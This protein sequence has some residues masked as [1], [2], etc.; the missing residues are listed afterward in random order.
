M[1]D[2]A[3]K[4]G[5]LLVTLQSIHAVVPNARTAVAAALIVLVA[6]L[7]AH[8]ALATDRPIA[9]TKLVLKRSASG[10]EK[11]IFLSK[12]PAFLFD[13]SVG[14]DDPAHAGATI[15]LF[16]DAEGVST[17]GVPAGSGV[18]GWV[19]KGASVPTFAYANKIAPAGPSLV[20]SLVLRHGKSMKLDARASGLALAAPEGAVGVRIT[21]GSFRNCVRFDGLT[22]HSDKPGSFVA[23]SVIATL[24]D[25]S[26]ASLSG[27][28]SGCS[29][30][31]MTCG[32]S[33][34]DGA[35]CATQDLSSCTC[36]SPAD[37][38][39][40]TY[41][42]CN[43]E[44]PAGEAC[45][46]TG[47]FPLSGCSCLPI[48]STPCSQFQCGGDCPAGEECNY[49]ERSYPGSSGCVCGPPG[50]CGSGGDDCPPGQHCA[51]GPPGTFCVP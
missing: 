39:G 12:D 43:G 49:F 16:S 47:G 44:C 3:R 5:T 27:E 45:F 51:T 28:S 26:R 41:P 36:I 10:K 22:I 1:R 11:V 35:T 37:P 6:M 48:G 29:G 42:V 34:P 46:A 23:S 30:N 8:R 14:N 21:I 13:A 17:L 15:E 2:R 25:C 40:F 19:V 32:G 31:G 7:A 20:R 24:T 18:P 38:C 50:G 4:D 33:C 9:A